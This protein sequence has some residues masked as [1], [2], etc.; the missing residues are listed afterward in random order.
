MH[1]GYIESVSCEKNSIQAESPPEAFCQM[2]RTTDK[3][4]TNKNR[5]SITIKSDRLSVLISFVT[6]QKRHFDN[7]CSISL[8]CSD[9]ILE[10]RKTLFLPPEYEHF[11]AD[12]RK[13]SALL[14]GG[15]TCGF[16]LAAAKE[17]PLLHPRFPCLILLRFVPRQRLVN[18]SVCQFL[19]CRWCQR[20]K[21]VICE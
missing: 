5:E 10:T 2:N 11:I 15:I 1:I 13:A 9:C 18:I 12:R 16:A 8:S 21:N 20:Y 3:Q 17:L 19:C 7:N 6:Q 4:R 14:P